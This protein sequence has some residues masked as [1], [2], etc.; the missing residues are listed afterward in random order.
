[1]HGETYLMHHGGQVASSR[2]GGAHPLE[3]KLACPKQPLLSEQ[4]S[5]AEHLCAGLHGSV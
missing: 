4:Q 3:R 1:M 5:L 2:S